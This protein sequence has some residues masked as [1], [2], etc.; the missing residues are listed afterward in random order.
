MKSFIF[1]VIEIFLPI[2][3]IKVSSP[4]VAGAGAG[5]S[6]SLVLHLR[7]GARGPVRHPGGAESRVRGQLRPGQRD[8]LEHGGGGEAGRHP[9]PAAAAA[10][11]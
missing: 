2:L 10:E 4:S 9:V 5:D 7:G 3:S 11:Q 6:D 1:S 8:Q